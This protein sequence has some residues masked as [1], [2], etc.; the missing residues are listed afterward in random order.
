MEMPGKCQGSSK[1]TLQREVT[2]RKAFAKRRHP[3]LFEPNQTTLELNWPCL[4]PCLALP[5][6]APRKSCSVY[7]RRGWC[8]VSEWTTEWVSVVGC[9]IKPKDVQILQPNCRR[10]RWLGRERGEREQREGGWGEE[11]LAGSN[12]MRQ[13]MSCRSALQSA[14]S[15][16]T[17]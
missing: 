4:V 16:P 8:P 6:H 11:T 1:R 12:W 9:A 2:A 3:L 17:A 15:E 10:T 5:R 14:T 13:Q 7:P